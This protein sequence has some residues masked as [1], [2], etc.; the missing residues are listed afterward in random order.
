MGQLPTPKIRIPSFVGI[1]TV[2]NLR[3]RLRHRDGVR[4]AN[5]CC[6]HVT[7]NL[8][9]GLRGFGGSIVG[10]EPALRPT[11]PPLIAVY[12]ARS[13]DGTS[14]RAS[15]VVLVSYIEKRSLGNR[16]ARDTKRATRESIRGS[17]QCRR[18]SSSTIC[19]KGCCTPASANP[20]LNPLYAP[21]LLSTGSQEPL[22]QRRGLC[23]GRGLL[24]P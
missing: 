2:A 3:D 7:G 8:G 1:C 19:A 23:R 24:R 5:L 22:K 11:L 14:M 6:G 20:A 9:R 13:E 21:A 4:H 17:A 12:L 16:F 15:G 18:S 10:G